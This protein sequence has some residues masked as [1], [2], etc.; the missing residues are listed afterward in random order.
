MILGEGLDNVF[1]R[2][3]RLGEACRRAVRAWGLEI[4][5][6]DP[7]V[8]PAIPGGCRIAGNFYQLYPS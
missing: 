4:Q 7:A 3:M 6:Q 5:C 1:A 2:H 8:Q